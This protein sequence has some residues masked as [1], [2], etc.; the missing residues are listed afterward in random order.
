MDLRDR[1]IVSVLKITAAR[2]SAVRLL[3]RDDLDLDRGVLRFRRGKGGK[4]LEVALQRE[5]RGALRAYLERGRPALLEEGSDDPGVLF[6]SAN[7]RHGL[8]PLTT[9]SLSLMLRR[10]YTAVAAPCSPSEPVASAMPRPPC[11]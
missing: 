10:R 7:T 9:N 4:T 11:S 3:R 1:A 5:T 6:P 8:R 2:N